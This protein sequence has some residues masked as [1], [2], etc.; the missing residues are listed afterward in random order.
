MGMVKNYLIG[1]ACLCSEE[2]FGQD[3]VDWA[4]ETGLVQ[5]TYHREQDL[6]LIMGEPG[7]PETGQYDAIIEAYR[8]YLADEHEAAPAC[9]AVASERRPEPV[10]FAKAA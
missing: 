9:Q 2:A 4:I 8:G 6:R 3:A 10:T 5:L 1:L 7:K